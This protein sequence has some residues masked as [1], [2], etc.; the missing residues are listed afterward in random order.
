[1]TLRQRVMEWT[2][3]SSDDGPVVR[4]FIAQLLALW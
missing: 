4:L 1:L 3:S 2:M